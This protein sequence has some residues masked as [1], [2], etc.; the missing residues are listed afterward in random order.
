MTLPFAEPGDRFLT[1]EMIGTIRAI[2]TPDL[3][4]MISSPAITRL[5]NLERCVLAS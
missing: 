2:G 5:S 1:F 3:A 4:I